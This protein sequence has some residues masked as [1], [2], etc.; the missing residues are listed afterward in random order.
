MHLVLRMALLVPAYHMFVS[1]V[2]RE[3]EFTDCL[4]KSAGNI[5]LR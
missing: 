5:V 2:E 3:R 4:G 1:I